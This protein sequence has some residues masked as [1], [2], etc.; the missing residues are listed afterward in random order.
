MAC[1][2]TVHKDGSP[3]GG[4]GSAFPLNTQIN[5]PLTTNGNV[6]D[7]FKTS[8]DGSKV[9]YVADETTDTVDDLYVADIPS[10]G[11]K[12]NLTNLGVGQK[13]SQFQISPDSSKVAFLANINN[14][15][16]YDLF[17]INMDGTDLEQVNAGLTNNAMKVEDNFVWAN[18]SSR[19]VFATDEHTLGTRN[20]YIA[21]YDGANYL[22]LNQTNGVFKIFSL[23]ED[24]SRIVYRVQKTNPDVRS[25]TLSATSDVLLNSAH[26]IINYPASGVFDFKVSKN[27]QK[28]IYRANETAIIDIF[29]VNIDGSGPRSKLNSPP[30]AGGQVLA[31]YDFIDASATK[32]VFIGDIDADNVD[33]LYV[34][35]INGSSKMKLSGTLV[36]GGDVK[37]FKMSPDGNRAIFLA[38]KDTDEIAELY[39]V[40]TVGGTAVKL[41]SALAVGEN[42]AD[43]YQVLSS[44]ILYAMDK[45]SAGI[46]SVYANN[47]LGSSEIR[48]NST[49]TTGIGFLDISQ[50]SVN[51]FFLTD[52]SSRVILLGSTDGAITSAYSVM[53]NGTGFTQINN[54]GNQVLLSPSSLGSTA[55]S[56]SPYI[57]YREYDGA[58]SNLILSKFKE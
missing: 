17:T 31:Q 14:P 56:V 44:Q 29:S 20:I 5:G 10:L 27:S 15:A 45:G 13:V 1:S 26:D 52:D 11:N 9:V 12:L 30:V 32:V 19:I 7:L 41:N 50:L 40:P 47:N 16:R 39:T 24:N 28:V 46:Y 51:Q 23:A 25:V 33:E 49:I 57:I 6:S 18:D 2:K 22:Q 48:L 34:A 38:D 54:T 43:Q 37:S 3:T 42:V 4:G 35:N 21:D 58:E 55:V 8:P 53:L 36:A